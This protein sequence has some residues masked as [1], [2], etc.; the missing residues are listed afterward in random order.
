MVYGLPDFLLPRF[1][2]PGSD[3]IVHHRGF[4]RGRPHMS[5]ACSAAATVARTGW[6]SLFP[7]RRPT[8]LVTDSERSS[9]LESGGFV[10]EPFGFFEIEVE[11]GASCTKP[12]NPERV[13]AALP[14]LELIG[15]QR[16]AATRLFQRQ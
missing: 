7:L 14:S 5:A 1:C 13:D 12:R 9:G 3:E 8:Q 15:I 4:L 11:L 10:H 6:A 16:V 2:Q